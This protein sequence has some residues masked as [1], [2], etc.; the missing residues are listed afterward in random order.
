MRGS[1][2]GR[3]CRLRDGHR[4]GRSV[5]MGDWQGHGLSSKSTPPP[6]ASKKRAVNLPCVQSCKSCSTSA[7]SLKQKYHPKHPSPWYFGMSSL[8]WKVEVETQSDLPPPQNWTP[9]TTEKS[10]NNQKPKIRGEALKCKVFFTPIACHPSLQKGFWMCS[11]C[12]CSTAI[13]VQDS[14]H[15]CQAIILSETFL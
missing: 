4:P 1:E 8:G 9:K 15:V 11:T 3:S 6:G 5:G 7:F 2:R 13:S 10:P 14:M 12:H